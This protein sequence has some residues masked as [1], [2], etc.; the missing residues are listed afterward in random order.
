MTIVFCILRINLVKIEGEGYCIACNEQASVISFSGKLGLKAM[1][2][3]LDQMVSIF[4]RILD[5][6]PPQITLNFRNLEFLN[7]LGISTISKF[8]IKVRNRKGIRV[9]IKASSDIPWQS[10]SLINLQRIMPGLAL[11]WE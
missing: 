8:V 1:D 10:K 3:A 6:E 5:E 7:S 11:I 2:S 4:N 9:I